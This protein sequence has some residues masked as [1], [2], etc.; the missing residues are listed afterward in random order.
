MKSKLNSSEHV[1]HKLWERIE[2][3]KIESNQCKT[4]EKLEDINMIIN[5]LVLVNS[6]FTKADD[7]K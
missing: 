3:L 6:F 5:E 1:Y 2:Y 7:E 4:Q